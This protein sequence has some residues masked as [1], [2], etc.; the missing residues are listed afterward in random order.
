MSTADFFRARLAEM[1][2]LRHP[3]AV[4]ATRMPWATLEAALAPRFA[5]RDR[6][7]QVL[8]V[9]DLFG[10]HLQVAGAGGQCR[11]ASQITRRQA[12]VRGESGSRITF[13]ATSTCVLVAQAQPNM[14]E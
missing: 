2:D 10:E 1:I 11:Q 14:P 4:L 7:G 12:E 3:L 5:R 8:W 9:E 6:P 13:F